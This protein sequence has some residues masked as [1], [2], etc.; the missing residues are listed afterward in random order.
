LFVSIQIWL[1]KKPVLLPM[2]RSKEWALS[3]APVI[4]WAMLLLEVAIS[5]AGI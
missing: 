1:W 3:V 2:L 4:K 5:A